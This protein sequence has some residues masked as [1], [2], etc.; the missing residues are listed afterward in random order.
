MA[1]PLIE[2]VR[3]SPLL[4]DVLGHSLHPSLPT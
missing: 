4:T 3:R 2:W 1:G